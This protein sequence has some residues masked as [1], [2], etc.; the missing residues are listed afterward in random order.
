MHGLR[1]RA[2]ITE[3]FGLFEVWMIEF[4]L[5]LLKITAIIEG[6]LPCQIFMCENH[7]FDRSVRSFLY[8]KA[9]PSTL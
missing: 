7:S 2:Q 9:G 1:R 5:Y 8:K 3:V 4:E 6:A